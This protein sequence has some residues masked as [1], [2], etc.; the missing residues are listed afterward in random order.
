MCVFHTNE[1]NVWKWAKKKKKMK[2]QR[3]RK[4]M[5]LNFCHCIVLIFNFICTICLFE[6]KTSN[7]FLIASDE[8][9]PDEIRV[10]AAETKNS[11]ELK[12]ESRRKVRKIIVR[13][14]QIVRPKWKDVNANARIASSKCTDAMR[15]CSVFLVRLHEDRINAE[16]D[17][18]EQKKIISNCWTK[19]AHNNNKKK[20]A[21]SG[22]HI[23]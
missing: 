2:M 19:D 7:H 17:L 18:C 4:T 9:R 12:N 8:P 10:R 13:C 14:A 5:K 6:Q 16:A 22:L 1:Q 21:W 11:L 23:N 15:R 3:R 20:M